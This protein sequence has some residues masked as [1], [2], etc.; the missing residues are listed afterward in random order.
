[1]KKLFILILISTLS[2][3]NCTKEDKAVDDATDV[4][5][6]KNTAFNM[7]LLNFHLIKY[8]SCIQ[9]QK[10]NEL[11]KNIYLILSSRKKTETIKEPAISTQFGSGY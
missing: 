7:S 4:V 5:N 1:M 10:I 9:S 6:K 11:E 8:V 2:Y 3:S